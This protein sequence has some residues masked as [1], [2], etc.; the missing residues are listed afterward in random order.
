MK[1]CRV[2]NT[3]ETDWHHSSNE[4]SHDNEYQVEMIEKCRIYEIATL[5][6]LHEL[7]RCDWKWQKM[8]N[9][10]AMNRI[11]IQSADW[12]SWKEIDV[13][14]REIVYYEIVDIVNCGTEHWSKRGRNSRKLLIVHER[15][16][17]I[18][19]IVI[20]S[21]KLKNKWNPAR[22]ITWQWNYAIATN[23]ELFCPHY[24]KNF[25]QNRTNNVY[26]K[27]FRIVSVSLV[28]IFIPILLEWFGFVV[29]RGI[30]IKSKSHSQNESLD[31]CKINLKVVFGYPTI[32]SSS[33]S[34]L[35]DWF[36][37]FGG[38]LSSYEEEHP[39]SSDTAIIIYLRNWNEMKRTSEWQKERDNYFRWTISCTKCSCA[40][41][42]DTL[43][44]S[45]RWV[46]YECVTCK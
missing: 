15:A 33:V 43:I 18:G 31:K 2:H 21:Y 12:E 22:I 1:L 16:I 8:R 36:I 6:W 45:I 35:T 14:I 23:N 29:H 32:R 42:P 37:G 7:V 20:G 3:T 34:S 40:S 25:S 44:I 27:H 4:S 26:S 39:S 17:T 24:D 19:W 5:K 28:T 30:M 10:S 13:N 9:S 38:W 41:S 11:S 46:T